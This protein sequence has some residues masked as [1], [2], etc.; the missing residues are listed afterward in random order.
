MPSYN[1]DDNGLFGILLGLGVIGGAALF[2]WSRRSQPSR[3]PRTV[4]VEIPEIPI[5]PSD[6]IGWV[7][8]VPSF[9]GRTPVISNEY[10][11][12]PRY[13]DGKLNYRAHLGVDI[14][15]RRRLGDPDGPEDAVAIPKGATS[16]PGWIAPAGTP[17]V[18]A[19]PGTIWSA[20]VGPLGR[21]VQ[22]DHGSVG[23]AG[24]VNTFYQ[25]LE[26]FERP[27]QKGDIVKAGDVIGT[28]GGD[29]SNAPHLR[30]LHFELWFPRPGLPAEN[31]P[32]D[33][34]P[35]IKMWGA[36]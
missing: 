19:G 11:P 23:S 21:S 1:D 3:S 26:S 29:P 6:W 13:V 27:W 30:H 4:D 10:K 25:H 8:P 33:P 34:E 28:M 20:D 36:S 18:A 2:F 35:F 7:Q 31:W 16:N 14:M 12:G 9:E 15:F 5:N 32:R 24:G 22:I 17:V